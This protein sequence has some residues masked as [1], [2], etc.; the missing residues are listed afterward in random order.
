MGELATSIITA[1]L[2]IIGATVI[3][4][5]TK[6]IEEFYLKPYIKLKRILAGIRYTLNKYSNIYTNLFEEKEMKETFKEEVIL[7]QSE[8]R[9][10]WARLDISYDLCPRVFSKKIPN[11]EEIN[12]IKTLLI[13]L[14]NAPIIRYPHINEMVGELTSRIERIR[15]ASKILNKYTKKEKG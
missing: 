8:A 6:I 7:S 13:Y 12:E 3:F 1:S 2:T 5:F 15:N 10:L 4:V 11:T 9:E 14:S